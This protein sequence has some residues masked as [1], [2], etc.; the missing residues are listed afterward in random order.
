MENCHDKEP[1]VAKAMALRLNSKE[2]R[3][4]FEKI[5]LLGNFY[6]N[7][8]VLCLG[9]GELKVVRRPSREECERDA[10]EFLPCP[11][12]FGFIRKKDL[13]KHAKKCPFKLKDKG[14]NSRYL[15]GESA[16]LLANP[17]SPRD[18]GEQLIG[19]V[20]KIMQQDNIT[21]TVRTDEVILTLGESLLENVGLEKTTYVSQRMR[22]I[23]RLLRELQR[24]EKSK[25]PLSSFL[26][27]GKFDL[28]IEAVRSVCSY[29]FPESGNRATIGIPSLA[30]KL[31]N[32]LRKCA[33]IVRGFALRTKDSQ[34]KEDVNSY[35]ELHDS[36]WTSKVSS[37]ALHT[38]GERKFN[39]PEFF[40]L[41]SDL[42]QLR[43]FQ[44]D[45][46]KA[47]TTK[48]NG[49]EH[50]QPASTTWASLAEVTL[51]RLI[52]F[53]KRRGGEAAKLLVESYRNRPSW[54]TVGI[55]EV[56]KS[57]NPSEQQLIKRYVYNKPLSLMY[58]LT[59]IENETVAF[60]GPR[61]NEQFCKKWEISLLGGSLS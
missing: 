19:S 4:A 26:K 25:E 18:V 59:V 58:V 41:T 21:E 7:R 9:K 44:I 51:T 5:R 27:P 47:L 10:S 24:R 2:R 29:Q 49:T 45:E 17:V 6:H 1:E 32:S 43:K 34:L 15:R 53:N 12:C 35:L 37:A 8:K 48:V 50:T 36:E 55:Q 22:E 56:Q 16:L 13:T 54:N 31:G 52:L 28:I 61:S 30:L 42:V 20:L 57:L 38:L 40:P 39:K 11:Y 23:A 3:L 14:I 60:F 46:I 33:A